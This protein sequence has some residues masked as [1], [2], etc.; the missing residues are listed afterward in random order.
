VI[1]AKGAGVSS[2]LSTS[3]EKRYHRNIHLPGVGAEGQ[4]KLLRAS[5][6]IVG[7]GGLGS[8]AAYYLAAAG[9]GRLGIADGDQVDL[10]NLQRQILHFTQDIGR[11]KVESAREKLTALNPDCSVEMHQCAVTQDNADAIVSQYDLVIDATDNFDSRFVLNKACLAAGKLF[12]HAAVL[13]MAGRVMTVLPHK[14]PCLRCVFREPPAPTAK[15][16]SEL[17]VLGS[18]PGLVAC[19]QASEAVKYLLGQGELL[20]GRILVVDCLAMS[21]ETVAV[22]RD[23]ECPDCGSRFN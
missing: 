1:S 17:G 18:V 19:V 10:S 5:A 13:S 14:G 2:M 9:I 21:F 11:S 12:V 16:T 15:S 20:V 22:L 8:P 23:P 7:M 4:L 3:Q 6:L